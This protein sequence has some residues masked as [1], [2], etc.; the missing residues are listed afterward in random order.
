MNVMVYMLAL[1]IYSRHTDP[2]RNIKFGVYYYASELAASAP[3]VWY[4]SH[5]DMTSLVIYMCHT[6]TSRNTKFSVYPIKTQYLLDNRN[7]FQHL[8]T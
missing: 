6:V 1:V 4:A 8:Q 2:S 5:A 3:R 7:D